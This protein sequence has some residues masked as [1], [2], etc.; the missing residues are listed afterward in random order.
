MVN[1]I[2]TVATPIFLLAKAT[3]ES[4]PVIW[5]KVLLLF[6][7]Q[8]EVGHCSEAGLGASYKGSSFQLSPLTE[9]NDWKAPKKQHCHRPSTFDRMIDWMKDWFDWNKTIATRQT[10]TVH[11][12]WVMDLYVLQNWVKHCF[13]LCGW[14]W[15]SSSTGSMQAWRGK[16]ARFAQ[17]QEIFS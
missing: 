2:I 14:W 4:G 13:A 3:N 7:E 8:Q 1:P 11:W 10:I 6:S 17:K 9:K 16:H 15:S 12:G 5:Y